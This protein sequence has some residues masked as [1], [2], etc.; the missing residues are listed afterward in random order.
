MALQEDFDGYRATAEAV[1]E[2]KDAEL[3]KAL[4]GNATL[5]QQLADAQATAAQVPTSLELYLHV[6]TC[7][8]L[9]VD[10]PD[11][12]INRVH[13]ISTMSSHACI[14]CLITRKAMPMTAIGAYNAPIARHKRPVKKQV[15]SPHVLD[16]HMCQH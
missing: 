7:H 5:R 2:A 6:S 14:R 9:C 12:N 8:I 11:L 3:A 4:E 16:T 13:G 1:A 10:V 15:I